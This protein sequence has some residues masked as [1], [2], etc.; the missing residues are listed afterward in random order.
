MKLM[1]RRFLQPLLARL[2]S[3]EPLFVLAKLECTRIYFARDYID[4]LA[5][6]M[7]KTHCLTRS[8]DVPNLRTGE[9]MACEYGSLLLRFT[10]TFVPLDRRNVSFLLGVNQ[11]RLILLITTLWSLRRSGLKGRLF[12]RLVL[13][14]A[15]C[16]TTLK[17]AA[18]AHP[19]QLTNTPATICFISYSVSIIQ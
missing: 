14:V 4:V 15:K 16:L 18:G 9:M 10:R 11:S 3:W 7:I 6:F 19:P 8:C 17:I 12:Q 5:T 2:C 13:S 1:F